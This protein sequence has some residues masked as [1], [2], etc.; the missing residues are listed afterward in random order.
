M[1]FFFS[2]SH[3]VTKILLEAGADPN[4]TSD[5]GYPPLLVATYSNFT[6]IIKLLMQYDVNIHHANDMGYQVRQAC[7]RT[8]P[9]SFS[10]ICISSYPPLLV[11]AI[12]VF[13]LCHQAVH[14]AAWNGF[15]SILTLLLNAGAD[16][17]VQTMDRNTPMSLAA[18]GNHGNV[19]DM[20]LAR[21]CNVNNADKDL[22]TP[23]LYATYNGNLACVE[24]LLEN[25][26]LISQHFGQALQLGNA[27]TENTA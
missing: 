21:G 10:F 14:I 9:F 2:D 1:C 19:V 5:D 6:N 4:E 23:L 27:S 15:V 22:D 11:T 26:G 20:L 16:H 7:I 8:S 12:N 24:S 18:H 25:G 3:D 17:D 13:D